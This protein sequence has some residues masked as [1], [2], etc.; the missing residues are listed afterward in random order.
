MSGVERVGHLRDDVERPRWRECALSSKHRAQVRAID[1]THRE[2][3]ACIRLARVVDRDDVGMIEARSEPR[4]AEKALAKLGVVDVTR[5][6]DLEGDVPVEASVVR[7]VHLAHA[8]AS[9]QLL[10]LVAADL[11]TTRDPYQ[12][13]HRRSIL[14]HLAPSCTSETEPCGPFAWAKRC[15]ARGRRH[16]TTAVKRS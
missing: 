14:L 1:V 13:G 16:A 7:P 8:A 11:D 6:E 5:R 9:D 15:T 12:L 2:V 10:N 4:L 3:Q